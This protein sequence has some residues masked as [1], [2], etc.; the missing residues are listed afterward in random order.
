MRLAN[1]PRLIAVG[2]I[3]GFGI[4]TIIWAVL[5]WH[6][7]DLR[8]YLAAAELVRAG[9]PLYG[10]EALIDTPY[11][12]APWFAYAMLPFTYLP[13]ELTRVIWS[14]FTLGGTALAVW[15]LIRSRSR[16]A[17]L[18]AAL[19]GPLLVNIS[20][21]G[22]VQGPMLALLMW[23]I[24]RRWG[25]LAIGVAAS[26]K[27]TPL[28]LAAVYIARREYRQAILSVIVTALLWA[29]ALFF[30]FDLSTFGAD[31]LQAWPRTWMW[32]AAVGACVAVTGVL[33]LRHSPY[34]LLAAAIAVIIG[35]Q[36]MRGYDITWIIVGAALA[37]Y[38]APIK[39]K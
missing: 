9:E 26:L 13:I 22:N 16:E 11:R 6:L 8:V 19:F 18:L 7:Y 2:L 4:G 23:G 36:R 5:D 10:S 28:I 33:A 34:T 24:P 3:A 21:G 37:V 30:A 29:P 14:V 12:Y 15:P 39:Q 1:L 32:L 38:H 31:D 25:P 17:L 27:I 35:L 20:T